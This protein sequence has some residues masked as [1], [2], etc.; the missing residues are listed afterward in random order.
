MQNLFSRHAGEYQHQV[1]T[2]VYSALSGILAPSIFTQ[3][4]PIFV[5]SRPTSCIHA[6]VDTGLRQHDDIDT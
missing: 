5:L 1:K 3:I 4:C 2:I 6:V